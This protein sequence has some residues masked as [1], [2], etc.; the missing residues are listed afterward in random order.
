MNVV[1]PFLGE[2]RDEGPDYFPRIYLSV[3]KEGA[4]GS[5]LLRVCERGAT[6]AHR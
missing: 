4:C 1:P 6:G 2:Q 5:H 3:N